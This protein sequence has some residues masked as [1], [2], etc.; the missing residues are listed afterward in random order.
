MIPPQ[1]A[2]DYA[3]RRLEGDGAQAQESLRALIFA[4]GLERQKGGN[5]TPPSCQPTTPPHPKPNSVNCPRRSRNSTQGYESCL[6]T[7]YEE[8]ARH[9]EVAR[10]AFER[11]GD[12]LEAR[13]A[14]YWIAYCLTQPGRIPE[15]N[16]LLNDLA[17]FCERRG[18]K[19]LLSQTAG[20]LGSNHTALHEYS[21]AI[22]YNRQSLALAEEISIRI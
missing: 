10:G 4:G 7:R 3:A 17:E 18:Y 22:K 8:A 15:S 14:D 9:F 20:W 5:H 16:A 13:I 2:H 1:L 19:W 6:A 21:T 11:A 12:E